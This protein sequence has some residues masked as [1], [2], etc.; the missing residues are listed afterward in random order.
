MHRVAGRRPFVTHDIGRE[1]VVAG[2]AAGVRTVDRRFDAR[3]PEIIEGPTVRGGGIWFRFRLTLCREGLPDLAIEG[4]LHHAFYDGGD[5]IAG[6]NEHVSLDICEAAAA[7]LSRHAEK[8]RPEGSPRD[9]KRTPAPGAH[10]CRPRGAG[11]E[12]ASGA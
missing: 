10:R 4:E 6:L 12:P 1:A 8:L 9:P 11:G 2:L 3:I 7:Y 5:A